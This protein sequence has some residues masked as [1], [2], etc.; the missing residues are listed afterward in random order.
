MRQKRQVLII[1]GALAMVLILAACSAADQTN[2]TSLPQISNSEQNEDV[3]ELRQNVAQVAG[4]L[5]ADFPITIYQGVGYQDG[6]EVIFSELLAQGK[7][8][9]LNFWAGLCPPCR[10]EMPDLQTVSDAYRDRVL[11]FGLDVG[12]FTGLGTNE[13]GR[14]LLQ[15]LA[16][17]YPAGTTSNQN[18]VREYE[19]L[20]MPTTYFI[21]PDGNVYQTWTGLLTEA[22]LTELVEDLLAAST[23]SE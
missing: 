10:L 16:I 20:G 17:T 12:P 11:L 2:T 21:T 23:N 19:I 8:V 5:P 22:K 9:V 7:P 3:A 1:I 4:N 14:A 15:E 13:D 6:D 18:V